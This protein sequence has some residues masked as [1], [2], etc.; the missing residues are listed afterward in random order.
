ML[1]YTPLLSGWG[2][3]VRTQGQYQSMDKRFIGLIFS[4]FNEDKLSK[5]YLQCY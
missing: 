1:F 5:V 2:P 4:V 3:D